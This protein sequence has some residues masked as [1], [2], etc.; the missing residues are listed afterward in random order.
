MV[1]YVILDID[2]HDSTGYEEYRNLAAPTVTHYDGRFLVRGGVTETLE[3][4]WDPKRLVIIEFPSVSRA[5]EWLAS[6]EYEA[7]KE[8]RHRTARTNAIL[9]A[10]I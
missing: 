6:P 4:D 9:V 10:G 7:A 5:R 2:V 3:G 8:I 1:A